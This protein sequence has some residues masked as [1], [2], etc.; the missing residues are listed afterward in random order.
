VI[1][2]FLRYLKRFGLLPFGVY[3]IL[4][5]A[6]VIATLGASAKP[7]KPAAAASAAPSAAAEAPAR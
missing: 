5:G 7:L 1:A 3:R 2:A 6:I 4:L